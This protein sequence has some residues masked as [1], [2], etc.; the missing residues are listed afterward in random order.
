MPNLCEDCGERRVYRG[1]TLCRQCRLKPSPICT[2]CDAPRDGYSK[3]CVDCK[4]KWNNLMARTRRI[5]R[6]EFN[7]GG[8]LR[9]PCPRCLAP[10][11]LLTEEGMTICETCGYMPDD[12]MRIGAWVVVSQTQR[13]GVRKAVSNIKGW[14]EEN[15]LDI[16]P[17]SIA[18]KEP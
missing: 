7:G 5:E 13:N 10:Q 6:L 15:G 17:S 4:R 1:G 9:D 12:P 11:G 14:A 16:D 3:R 2:D 8:R 18:T